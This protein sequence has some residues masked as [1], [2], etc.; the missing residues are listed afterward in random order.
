[1]IGGIVAALVIALLATSLFVSVVRVTGTSM[2]PALSAGD[3]VV[4]V[5]AVRCERGEIC[6]FNVNGSLELK[7]VIARGGD[8]VNIDADGRVYVNGELLDEPYIESF[9]RGRCT[10]KLP[11]VV[12][13][14][15]L[16]VLGDDRQNSVDSR[17]SAIGCI[18]E[19]RV[20]GKLLARLFPFERIGV[21]G[22][23]M[24]YVRALPLMFRQV[25][26]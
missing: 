15:S 25:A 20:E 21:L 3:Y 5:P 1:M 6:L 22:D 16:F 18:P 23:L 11:C 24:D 7:R 26:P 13:E 12:P 4:G 19:D 14:G 17:L 10:L 9:H 2:A 8:E